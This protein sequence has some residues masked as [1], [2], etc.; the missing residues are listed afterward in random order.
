MRLRLFIFLASNRRVRNFEARWGNGSVGGFEHG[1]CCGVVGLTCR[2]GRGGGGDGTGVGY[3][4]HARYVEK[5]R[6]FF[7]STSSD[8]LGRITCFEVFFLLSASYSTELFVT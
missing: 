1:V 4:L 2:S 5:Y 3:G 8:Y 7:G 6:V